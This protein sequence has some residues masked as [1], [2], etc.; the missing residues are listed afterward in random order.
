MMKDKTGVAPARAIRGI[1]MGMLTAGVVML[2]GCVLGAWLMSAQILPEGAGRYAALAVC[3]AGTLAG[4]ALAQRKAG[5]ARLPVS[6]GCGA[7]LVLIM[8]GVHFLL[9]KGGAIG[10]P[11]PAIVMGASVLSALLGAS[12]RRRR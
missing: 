2:A 7:A 8:L 10:M 6:V 3:L 1:I 5:G 12:G 11:G 9:E 4:C